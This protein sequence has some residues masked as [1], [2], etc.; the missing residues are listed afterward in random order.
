MG[1]DEQDPY[2]RRISL[3]GYGRIP[4]E[5]RRFH[6]FGGPNEDFTVKSGYDQMPAVARPL[7]M[8]RSSDMECLVFCLCRERPD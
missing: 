1:R 8:I 3:V 6:S 5:V 2:E 7:E 4:Q